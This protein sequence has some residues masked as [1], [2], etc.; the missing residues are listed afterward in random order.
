MPRTPKQL[1]EDAIIEAILEIRFDGGETIPEIAV[2]R[3]E[4]DPKVASARF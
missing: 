2:G 4:P 1:R 3:L